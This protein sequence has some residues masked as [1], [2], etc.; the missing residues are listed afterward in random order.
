MKDRDVF[1]AMDLI[2]EEYLNEGLDS[3]QNQI[4]EK[5]EGCRNMIKIPFF[6]TVPVAAAVAI[7]ILAA[8]SLTTYA[9]WKFFSA[10]QVAEIVGDTKLA[11]AFMGEGAISVNESQSYGDYKV[12]LLGTTS[13]K[14]ISDYMFKRNG[15]LK[16]DR[17]Y[18]VISISKK[19]GSPMP[20]TDTNSAG[21]VK[22]D[23]FLV[24]PFIKGENPADINLFKINGS[25][26][27]F[28]EGGVEYQIVSCDNLEAFAKRGV[29]LGVLM[30]QL[31]DDTAYCFDKETGEITR[32]EDFDGMNLLFNLPLDEAKGDEVAAKEQLAK[33][34]EDA[35]KDEMEIEVEGGTLKDNTSIY[36]YASAGDEI[37]VGVVKDR[38][39]ERKEE[40]E[41]NAKRV[42]KE[43]VI[44]K[45]TVQK[46]KPNEDGMIEYSWESGNMGGSGAVEEDEIF[47][48]GQ[49][50]MSD[51]VELSYGDEKKQ[52]YITT[53]S[54]NE[55]GTV[56][57]ALYRKK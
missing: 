19:D 49:L 29:Y 31:I 24:S 33:W 56:T 18:A 44:M 34:N 45:E 47:K 51:M 14:N 9:A 12:T 16:D 8:G 43:A 4:I 26:T 42:K 23:E 5:K 32:N 27:V 10:K 39:E 50:G 57:V 46:V 30:I 55:D 28:M 21:M 41:W 17:T 22:K 36:E 52:L 37:I 53:F 6:K 11:N 2:D 48:D 7:G 20:E 1:K 35:G 3:W 25:R 54:R 13:G 15:E 40:K 38:E